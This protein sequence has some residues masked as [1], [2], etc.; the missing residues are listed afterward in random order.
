MKKSKC[1]F[2]KGLTVK[3]PIFKEL[4]MFVGKYCVTFLR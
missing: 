2:V 1:P 3:Q 4:I